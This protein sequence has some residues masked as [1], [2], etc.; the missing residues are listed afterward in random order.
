M[1]SWRGRRQLIAFLIV[2]TPIVLLTF[3]VIKRLIPEPTC[4]DTK[5]NQNETGVDCGGSC[6]SCELKN[7]QPITVF[8]ARAVQTRENSYDVAAEI[9]NP[10]EL[11]SSVSVEYEFTLLDDYGP[12][13]KRTGATYIYAQERTLVIEPS[14][15]TSRKANRAEF[16]IIRV[17]WQERREL[18]PTIVAERRQYNVVQDHGQ[19]QSVVELTLFNQSPFDFLQA[20]IQVAA[21]DKD[22]N[23]LGVNKV[24]VENFL[25]QSRQVIKSLWPNELAG[26]VATIRVEPRVNI[27]DPHTI[28]KPQ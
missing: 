15:E 28:L 10:N 13:T 21:L 20:E 16:K 24:R 27:F 3:F 25:S 7:P 2:V 14:I 4:F 6:V 19:K 17:G 1:F 23:L 22:E 11:L 9:E 26:E 5:Q 18:K 8:W 12:I